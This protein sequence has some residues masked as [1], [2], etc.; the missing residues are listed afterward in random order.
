M[1]FVVADPRIGEGGHWGKE[2]ASLA[3]SVL[4]DHSGPLVLQVRGS[5]FSGGVNTR[6]CAAES[7]LSFSQ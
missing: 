4:W 2:R 3:C 6:L 7:G 1:V 5:R